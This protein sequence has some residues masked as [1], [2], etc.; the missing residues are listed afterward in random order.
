LVF[1]DY[2]LFP[3]LRVDANLRYGMRRTLN[4]RFDFTH[5]VEVLELGPLLHRYPATLSGGERQRVA[6]GRAVL[7]SPELLLLDE[8]LNSLDSELRD[9]A[10]RWLQR[11][12]S[13]YPLPT[14]LV[15]HE[16]ESVRGL[17]TGAIRVGA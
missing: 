1:Q 8:P 7:R 9:S 3:H 16:L 5:A 2:Q 4:P 12:L 17:V 10:M 14:L 11:L 15:T 6:L 13:E